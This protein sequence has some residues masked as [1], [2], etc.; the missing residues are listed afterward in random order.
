MYYPKSHITPN[1]YS[2][3]ELSIK[4]SNTPY[5]G[6]YFKTL[7]G[8]QF[9]ITSAYRNLDHQARLLKKDKENAATNSPHSYGGAI[10]IGEIATLCKNSSGNLTS[11][12]EINKRVRE[13]SKLYQWLDEN[14]PNYEDYL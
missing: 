4:N 12:P 7:D 11:N 5:T 8:K 13:N 2:N 9:T 3:G 14:G 10:D 1:L 6:Y